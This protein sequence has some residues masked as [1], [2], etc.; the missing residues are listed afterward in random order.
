MEVFLAFLSLT[1]LNAALGIDNGLVVEFKLRSLGLP[2]RQHLV[3]RSITLLL[4]AAMRVV[5]LFGL[6][7]LVPDERPHGMEQP[8]VRL[9]S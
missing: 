4:A 7:L 6:S 5:F 2:E 9:E 3:L 1:L 8:C